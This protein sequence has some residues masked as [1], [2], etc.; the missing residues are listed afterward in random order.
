MK[1]ILLTLVMMLAAVP[2][3]AEPLRQYFDTRAEPEAIRPLFR[4]IDEAARRIWQLDPSPERTAALRALLIA[5]DATRRA[6][7]LPISRPMR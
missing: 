6:A 5:R 7:L 2:V 4:P 1:P 3:A